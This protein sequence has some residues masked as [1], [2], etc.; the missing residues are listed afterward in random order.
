[1]IEINDTPLRYYAGIQIW[2]ALHFQA[3]LHYKFPIEF[4]A[5]NAHQIRCNLPNLQETA[6]SPMNL[7]R[8]RSIV[9][10]RTVLTTTE[11]GHCFLSRALVHQYPTVT[12]FTLS[13]LELQIF[14]L[15]RI[16][17]LNCH[18]LIAANFG[19]LSSDCA[20]AT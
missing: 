20:S 4:T 17:V 7:G 18:N 5:N 15:A 3:D 8:R 2:R 11:Q 6:P 12:Q 1:M 10:H 13:K 19:S 14:G 9:M 16:R